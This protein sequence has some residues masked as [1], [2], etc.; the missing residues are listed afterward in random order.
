MLSHQK[1]LRWSAII[2]SHPKNFQSEKTADSKDRETFVEGSLGLGWFH[3]WI[4]WRMRGS[5]Y[6]PV[7]S[8]RM[9][10][11]EKAQGCKRA[12][13]LE[14]VA[15]VNTLSLCEPPTRQTRR[16][17]ILTFVPYS[18]TKPSYPHTSTL[19]PL[20]VATPTRVSKPRTANTGLR[21]HLN[22]HIHHFIWYFT[23]DL[24]W[25]SNSSRRLDAAIRLLNHRNV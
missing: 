3:G 9:R 18:H 8:G 16:R 10:S 14:W 20:L 22:K 25:K 12:N 15:S 19:W 23:R 2:Y 13:S 7:K 1:I 21:V 17:A 11:I 24:H 6:G 5:I 4:L